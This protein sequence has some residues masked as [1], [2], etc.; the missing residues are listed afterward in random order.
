VLYKYKSAI[1]GDLYSILYA[2]VLLS[3]TGFISLLTSILACA[4][5]STEE[6]VELYIFIYLIEL[7]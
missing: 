1:N 2:A 7:I 4:N 3:V 6:T 5:C